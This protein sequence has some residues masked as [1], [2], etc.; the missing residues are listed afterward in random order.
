MKHISYLSYI[1]IYQHF[2]EHLVSQVQPCLEA[3][4]ADPQDPHRLQLLRLP[5]HWLRGTWWNIVAM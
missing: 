3:R 2:A 4:Q 1:F 5:H